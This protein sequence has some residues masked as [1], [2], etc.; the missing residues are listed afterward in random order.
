MVALLRLNKNRF[1][2]RLGSAT[3]K[4]FWKAI[5][6]LNKRESSIPIRDNNGEKV[7]S[8]CNK[9]DLLSTHFYECFNMSVPLLD[10]HH[11]YLNPSNFPEELQCTEDDVYDL[12]VELDCNKSTN[13]DD[14][15]AKMLK[16][17]ATSVTPSLT[18]L[19]NLSLTTGCFP[20]AWKLARVVPV[21]KSTDMSRPYQIKDPFPS[22]IISKILEHVIYRM[23]FQ[24]LCLSHP[25]G[26]PTWS[27]IY[28]CCQLLTTGYTTLTKAMMSVLCTLI[29]EKD[30]TV[31]PIAHYCRSL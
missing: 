11:P 18:H 27:V 17:T 15:S 22:S 24:H 28:F 25:M 6:I 2:R 23:I 31:S 1:F 3:S 26:L 14:I 9:A 21:P 7:E 12:I 29:F 19:S 30:S 4:E 5:K 10:N 20:D 16:G 8:S 13:P